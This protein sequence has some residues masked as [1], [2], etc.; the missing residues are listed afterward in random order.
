MES[1]L[2][3]EVKPGTSIHR[4]RLGWKWVLQ[5][6]LVQDRRRKVLG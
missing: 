4:I 6:T 5:G 2:M 1:D 3:Q